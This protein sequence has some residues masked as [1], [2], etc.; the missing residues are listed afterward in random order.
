ME[1]V[2]HDYRQHR[3][4]DELQGRLAPGLNGDSKELGRELDLVIGVQN[5]WKRVS[6]SYAFGRFERGA[7]FD[8]NRHPVILHRLSLRVTF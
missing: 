4:D 6:L 8:D 2:Y 3:L 1:A 5:L 7:A